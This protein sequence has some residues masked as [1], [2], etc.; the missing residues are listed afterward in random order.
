[1]IDVGCGAVISVW[2]ARQGWQ[3][4]GVD[5]SA[6]AV[7]ASTDSLA[8][9]GL[10]GRVMGGDLFSPIQGRVDMVVTNPPFHDRRQRTTDI[11][12]RLIAEAPSH[13][14]SGGVLWLVAN[15][16]LPYGSGWMM[17]S[18]CR[19][20]AKP[21]ASGLP[22]GAVIKPSAGCYN[23]RSRAIQLPVSSMVSGG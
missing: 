4:Q 11:T 16:E 21:P 7:A 15:R 5:V 13:L 3:V 22:G 10:Q 17:L 8:R 18:S 23:I 9:N 14:K 2:L 19:W 6:S 12:R 1:M 20:P